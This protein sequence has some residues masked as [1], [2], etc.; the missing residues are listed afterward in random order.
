MEF[1]VRMSKKDTTK[2]VFVVMD[3]TQAIMDAL[4][5]DK[6]R[7]HFEYGAKVEW[8]GIARKKGNDALLAHLK[9]LGLEVDKQEGVEVKTVDETTTLVK[10][11]DDEAKAKVMEYLKSIGKA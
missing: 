7:A 4:D 5:P 8:Q 10:G 2:T 3:E 11:L 1:S 9:A 6:T